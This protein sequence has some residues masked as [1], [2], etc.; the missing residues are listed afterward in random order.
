MAFLRRGCRRFV[1][2]LVRPAVQLSTVSSNSLLRNVGI[3]AHIDAGKTTTTERMLRLAGAVKREGRVD[4]GDT[5][6]DFLQQ[7]RERGITIQSAAVHFGWRDHTICLVDTPGHVDFTIEVER[8]LRVLDGCVL[9]VDAVAGVQAQTETVWRQASKYGVPAVAFVNKMDREGAAF[10]AACKSI[11]ERLGVVTLPLQMPIVTKDDAVVGSVDLLNMTC[12]FWSASNG[13]ASNGKQGAG[14]NAEGGEVEVVNLRSS[15]AA[16][17]VGLLDERQ[18]SELRGEAEE[19]R[20]A[21]LDTL[22]DHDDEFCEAVLEAM[23]SEAGSEGPPVEEVVAA[24]RRVVGKRAPP[25]PVPVGRLRGSGE[26]GEAGSA[27]LASPPPPPPVVV[28]PVLLGASLRGFG[29]EALLD[30]VVALLPAPGDR[31]KPTQLEES[32]AGGKGKRGATAEEEVVTEVATGAGDPLIALA[33]KVCND[34]HRGALVYLRVFGGTLTKGQVL[35]CCSS[36]GGGGGG[37][38]AAGSQGPG[39]VGGEDS[40]GGGGGMSKERV[41]HLFRPFADDFVPV[42]EG[43]LVGPGETVVA[44]GLKKVRTGDTLVAF[45]GPLHARGARLQGISV[46]HPV[47]ALSVSPSKGSSHGKALAEAAAIMSR[48]DPSLVVGPDP[49][50]PNQ[51]MMQGMGELHLEVACSRL[52]SDFKVPVSTGRVRIAYR[53]TIANLPL[54][55]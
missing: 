17:P 42:Q 5:T 13:E 41:L 15:G 44:V 53:E 7:E 24:L 46:P 34:Q 14:A 6:T 38:G 10:T 52:G 39:G 4:D 33:F 16:A 26:E 40:G 31:P 55:V 51:L 25:L 35:A 2:P 27:V 30:S 9:V 18:F 54:F 45:K 22:A 32:A 8:S 47:F 49:E 11:G 50:D 21:L 19:A 37:S 29:V 1:I 48:D 20:Q 43:E 3:I 12:H 23:D 28:V 36:S